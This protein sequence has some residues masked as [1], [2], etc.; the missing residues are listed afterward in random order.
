MI[1]SHLGG[2]NLLAL[3]GMLSAVRDLLARW[4]A[5]FA[6][7]VTPVQ[8]VSTDENLADAPSRLPLYRECRLRSDLFCALDAEHGFAVDAMSS[9]ASQQFRSTGEPVPHL[10][11]HRD[12]VAVGAPVHSV[13][14]ST[15]KARG[16]VALCVHPPAVMF[17]AVTRLLSEQAVA[18]LILGPPAGFPPSSAC[19]LVE[20]HVV[21]IRR[22]PLNHSL[23]RPTSGGGWVPV[24]NPKPLFAY[25][26]DFRK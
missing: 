6:V 13:D 19:R 21:S 14:V 24:L 2:E 1:S 20:P 22:M 16:T 25:L 26:V 5:T 8:R 15:F 4:G 3:H 11:R 10:A 23:C 17:D 12:G 18:A 7:D 9:A